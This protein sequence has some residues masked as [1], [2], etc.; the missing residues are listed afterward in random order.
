MLTPHKFE[1]Q[2][3][4]DYDPEWDYN[5]VAKPTGIMYRTYTKVRKHLVEDF[6]YCWNVVFV[7][8]ESFMGAYVSGTSSYPIVLLCEKVMRE[9]ADRYG[10]YYEDMLLST[11]AHELYHAYQDGYGVDLD[12]DEAEYFGQCYADYGDSFLGSLRNAVKAGP[13]VRT[14]QCQYASDEPF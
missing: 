4:H 12:E 7:R 10:M 14:G 13:T 11:V 5:V 3:E 6:G 8:G 9:C 2:R 1:Q